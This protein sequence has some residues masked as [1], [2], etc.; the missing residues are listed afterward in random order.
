M[1]VDPIN[2]LR[3][4]AV[5]LQ[6]RSVVMSPRRFDDR[7]KARRA[8]GPQGPLGKGPKGAL[9]ARLGGTVGL[10][11]DGFFERFGALGKLQTMKHPQIAKTTPRAEKHPEGEGIGFE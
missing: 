6:C 9:W 3:R 4:T 8:Q 1:P 11:A 10:N 2:S 7:S 5:L